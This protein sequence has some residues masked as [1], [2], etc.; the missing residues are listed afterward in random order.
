MIRGGHG[1]DRARA[2]RAEA[3]AAGRLT[4]IVGP[5][6][7]R[8]QGMIPCDIMGE[9]GLFYALRAADETVSYTHL[10]VYKRQPIT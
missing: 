4:V 9:H 1:L 7:P 5:N 2:L 8:E 6:L 3:E 10:D